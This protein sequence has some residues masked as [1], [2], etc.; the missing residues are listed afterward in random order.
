M[1]ATGAGQSVPAHTNRY[2]IIAFEQRHWYHEQA[3]NKQDTTDHF[4]SSLY[5][6]FSFLHVT[7]AFVTISIVL[8]GGIFNLMLS[9]WCF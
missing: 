7:A 9:R 4:P 2:F 6:I 1:D 5:L 8:L 3:V